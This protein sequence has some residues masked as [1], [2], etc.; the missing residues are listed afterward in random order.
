[1]AGDTIAELNADVCFQP[2]STLKLLPYLHALIE[3]DKGADSLDGTTVSWVAP[4]TGTTADKI[5]KTC[6]AASAPN[7]ATGSAPLKDALPTMMWESH[8]RTLDAVL[9]RY[10]PVN[11]TRRA[12]GLGLR[13][14][15]MYFGCAQ[16]GGPQQ[17]WADNV[18][19]LT[20]FA[21]LFEGVEALDHVTATTT[22]QAFRDNMIVL[23]AA[24]GTSYSSP[25]TGRMSGPASNEFLRSLVE[26][27][28]GAA[29]LAI[30]PT[31]MKHVVVRFKGG[32]GGPS[33]TEVGYSDFR[34]VS[35]PIKGATGR[36]TLRKYLL[37]WYVYQLKVDI[38]P[39]E[40]EALDTFRLE[41]HAEPIRQALATW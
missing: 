9:N 3:I 4:T 2:L 12:Q 10:G 35:L 27:E 38:R 20:D 31:F 29:K 1:M 40:Q 32:G 24:P 13:Q 22:R 7:T 33:G 26:R 39:A 18:S 21:R 34:E 11:I 19:T 14:T 5:D 41:I 36:I 30:V 17:P 25:I 28:A 8:N 6:L 16:S 37:G 23:D 15:E